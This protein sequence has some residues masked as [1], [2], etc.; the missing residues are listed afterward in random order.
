MKALGR[1]GA[2]PIAVGG[3]AAVIPRP[4]A[5]PVTE[6]AD[7][8]IVA[9][10]AG[11]RWDDV[12]ATD[13]PTMWQLALHGSIGALSVRS[14]RRVT[15]SGDGWLTLGA[16]NLA[17][18]TTAPVT[19]QCPP[20]DV[21][22]DRPSGS[23]DGAS[24]TLPELR[25]VV[26]DNRTLPWRAEPGAL[27]EAVRC[28]SVYGPGAAI[29]AARPYGRIDRYSDN[30]VF[31]NACAPSILDLGEISGPAAQRKAEAKQADA[32]LAAFLAAPGDPGPFG[33]TMQT[34]TFS[35]GAIRANR[36]LS[37]WPKNSALPSARFGSIASA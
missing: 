15:C 24:A 27:A 18:F 5:P 11:L 37:P 28:T 22:I 25:A 26:N 31:D 19:Q 34:S 2:L 9:G 17:R 8:V 32:T 23:V 36:M 10:A 30:P 6:P 13:T 3:L 12:N 21:E 35:G 4:A 16:G 20:L 14:A 33:A 29:A 7:S 1:V